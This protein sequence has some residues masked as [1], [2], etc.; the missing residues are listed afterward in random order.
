V[1]G[2]V[3]LLP[4]PLKDSQSLLSQID[5]VQRT[6][7]KI[8]TYPGCVAILYNPPLNTR[9]PKHEWPYV[10]IKKSELE[11]KLIIE[12]DSKVELQEFLVDLWERYRRSAATDATAT[13]AAV[14]PSAK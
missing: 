8:G 13:G 11:P 2:V 9:V 10:Q 3:L 1:A 12:D 4:V 7:P 6:I 14:G 5:L